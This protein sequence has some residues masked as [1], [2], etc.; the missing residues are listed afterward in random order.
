MT[1]KEILCRRCV[2]ILD[3]GGNW[4]G[5]DCSACGRLSCLHLSRKIWREIR[6]CGPCNLELH[7]LA[8]ETPGGPAGGLLRAPVKR[9]RRMRRKAL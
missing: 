7:R 3:A 9:R 1:P 2:A 5:G 8:R 6:L 4:R